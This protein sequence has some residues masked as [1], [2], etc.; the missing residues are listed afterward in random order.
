MKVGHGWLS[1]WGY[2][3]CVVG[4]NRLGAPVWKRIMQ[5]VESKNCACTLPGLLAAHTCGLT[6]STGRRRGWGRQ[7][8]PS[9]TNT[10]VS[11]QRGCLLLDGRLGWPC[12]WKVPTAL[13]RQTVGGRGEFLFTWPLAYSNSTK[14]YIPKDCCVLVFQ[15][16]V[17]FWLV[18]NLPWRE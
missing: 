8:F 5:Q 4:G 13:E 18:F 1:L 11:F 12:H 15:Q 10:C 9:I 17:S 3:L 2:F 6:P 14:A 7:A 16:K